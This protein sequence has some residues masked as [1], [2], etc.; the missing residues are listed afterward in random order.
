MIILLC[1]SCYHLPDVVTVTLQYPPGQATV[2]AS[3]AWPHRIN[4][5]LCFG[6]RGSLTLRRSEILHRDAPARFDIPV[7]ETVTTPPASIPPKRAHG[8]ANF[9]HILRNKLSV[10]E[11]H[12][13]ELTVRSCELVDAARESASTGRRIALRR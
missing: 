3:W 1:Q 11:P 8:I 5:L 4:E 10:R 12:S 7:E 6:A 9:A 2:E 13:A